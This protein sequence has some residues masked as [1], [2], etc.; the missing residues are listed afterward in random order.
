M[1]HITYTRIAWGWGV[2]G[3]GGWGVAG[4]RGVGGLGGANPVATRR[5]KAPGLR[6]PLLHRS[7]VQAARRRHL[8]HPRARR[9]KARAKAPRAEL[10]FF[11]VLLALWLVAA[12]SLLAQNVE[13]LEVCL[14][15]IFG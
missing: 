4:L 11:C 10:F 6:L 8:A 12:L 13:G 1:V 9:A 2:G 7:K 3:L 14:I 5:R 15:E